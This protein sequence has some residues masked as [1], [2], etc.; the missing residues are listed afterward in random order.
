MAA[1]LKV[2]QVES[3]DGSTNIILNNSVTMAT[4]KTLP[5]PSLTGNLPAI[6]AANLTAI[7]AGNLTG[8]VADARISALTA[9]KLTGTIADARFP[10]TLPAASGVNLTALNATNLGSGTVPTARLG[11]GSAS[12]SV[13]LSGAGTW[14]AAGSTSASDLTSGTLPIARF[15]SDSIL[16]VTN[17][18]TGSNG[19]IAYN[20]TSYVN[21][22]FITG[23]ITPVA[24][25]SSFF[26]SFSG[27][28]PH[29][30]PS[31]GNYGVRW[32]VYYNVAGGS[33]SATSSEV[34]GATHSTRTTTG[35]SDY[36]GNT[37]VYHSPSYTSGQALQYKLYTANSVNNT[38][39]SYLNHMGGALSGVSG[40]RKVTIFEIAG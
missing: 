40:R 35:W 26:V 38:G 33:F 36:N 32:K 23:N 16:Q 10:A 21:S 28:I 20:S 22:G 25:G 6:S 27:F 2:D 15:P 34:D 24:T 30:N 37:E 4:N 19:T 8:T 7:P 9:S 3:V 13:F 5:A 17:T 29:V 1:K 14:I 12:S 11:S 39:H 31:N 18:S